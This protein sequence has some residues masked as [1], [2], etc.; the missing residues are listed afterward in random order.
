MFTMWTS[1]F[2]SD[3]SDIIVLDKLV[4]IYIMCVEP[5]PQQ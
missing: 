4:P 5:M 2:A 1:V 3:I